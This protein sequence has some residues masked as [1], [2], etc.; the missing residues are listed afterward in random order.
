[1]KFTVSLMFLLLITT[2]SSVSGKE[3]DQTAV[4]SGSFGIFVNGKRTATERFSVEQ[5]ADGSLVK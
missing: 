3:P 2:P 5:S 4:D 1:M